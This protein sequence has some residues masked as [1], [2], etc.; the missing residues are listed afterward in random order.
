MD[1]L[2]SAFERYA[3]WAADVSPLY[4]RLA[5]VAAD[6]PRL[7]ELAS[8]APPETAPQLLLAAVHAVVRSGADHPLERYYGAGDGR[9]PD[10]DGEGAGAAADH[11]R[12]FCPRYEDR[13][14][15]L[16][17]TRSVQTNDV[18]RSVVLLPAFEFVARLAGRRRL[19][20]VELGASAGLNANWDRYGYEYAGV[21]RAG[22][23]DSP[24]GLSTA[25]RGDRD[26]PLPDRVPSVIS[27]RGVDLNPLDPAD[28]ED[29][30]W[31]HALIPPDQPGRHERLE[32]ALDVAGAD[33]PSVEQGD[34]VE[35]VPRLCRGAPD[36]AALIVYST[37]VCYQLDD[38]LVA[39]LRETLR[40]IGRDRPLYWLSGDP[41]V[42][43]GTPTYRLVA[44]D[45]GAVEE[46]RL[47]RFESYG[48]WIEWL[49]E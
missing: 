15:E 14:R 49:A 34:L 45:G 17:R 48:E 3:A 21:G 28:P 40:T 30:Q 41:D 4:E 7:L 35:A 26:P 6:D 42:G 9:T 22:D 27:R 16:V 13:I 2:A 24:V 1:E 39:D 8:A 44:F 29:A 25:V 47:A 11:F 18:G 12:D 46:T 43:P 38:E 20:T 31:L 33:P 5:G 19:A 23:P 32:A 10:G 36:A 37:L